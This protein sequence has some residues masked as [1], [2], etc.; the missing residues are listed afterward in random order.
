MNLAP[1]R[2]FS[3][4]KARL[5]IRKRLQEITSELQ[6]VFP[7]LR[8]IEL[9]RRE[10][11]F[12]SIYFLED[13]ADE[14]FG[15]MR[16]NNPSQVR[17]AVYPNLPRRAPSPTERIDREWDA[18]SLL[19]PLRLSPWPLWRSS[20][21]VVCSHSPLPSLRT[22]MEEGKADLTQAFT[23]VFRAI[24]KMHEAGVVHL[25]LSPGNILVCPKTSHA[26]LID[27]EYVSRPGRTF[28]E[29]CRFDRSRLIEKV[30]ARAAKLK[31]ETEVTACIEAA[32]LAS[33][34]QRTTR[35]AISEIAVPSAA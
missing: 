34:D 33:D 29:D 15:V 31:R 4:W 7:Q 9:S 5:G 8:S 19:A 20:D 1:R 32:L 22:L 21:A 12:D 28:D 24:R 30:L 2:V 25:D 27:F 11:G 17:T 6:I 23:A 35:A 3:R 18:Y 16:L 14:R 10:G 26:L 13:A